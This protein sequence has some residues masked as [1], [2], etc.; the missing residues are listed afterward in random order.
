MRSP[1]STVGRTQARDE[2]RSTIHEAPVEAEL[3][4]TTMRSLMATVGGIGQ[5]LDRQDATWGH[6]AATWPA[7]RVL[8]TVGKRPRGGRGGKYQT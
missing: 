1:K 7:I 4:R 3:P 8:S 2:T 5:K 6:Q